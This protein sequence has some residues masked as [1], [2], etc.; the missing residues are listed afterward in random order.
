[1]QRAGAPA[2]RRLLLLPPAAALLAAAWVAPA[3]VAPAVAAAGLVLLTVAAGRAGGIASAALCLA[4]PLAG[5]VQAALAVTSLAYGELLERG[6]RARLELARRSLTD[7][8]TGLHNYDYFAEALAGEV[9]RVRRYGGRVSL[10][11]LDLDRFKQLN[12]EH[13][14]AAGNR[15]LQA[16]GGLVATEKRDADVSARF[17][18]EEFAVLVAGG[19]HEAVVVAE[20]LR[21]AVRALRPPPLRASS[22]P[23]TASAGVAAFPDDAHDAGS[24]FEAADRALYAAKDGGRDRVV[25]AA[26]LA[27]GAPRLAAAGG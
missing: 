26:E 18:G 19:A 16:V 17:G 25:S 9:A 20:R 22:T 21:R 12:D 8:L 10:V 27:A 5:P 23:V 1:M 14:H 11:L 4:T 24:L 15:V 7:A 6:R 3:A 13:G 2:R